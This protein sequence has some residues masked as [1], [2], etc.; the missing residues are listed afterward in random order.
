MFILGSP[1]DKAGKRFGRVAGSVAE[2]PDKVGQRF[3]RVTGSV[4]YRFRARLQSV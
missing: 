1:L 4:P 3:G 2:P